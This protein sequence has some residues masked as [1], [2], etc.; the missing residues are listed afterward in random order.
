MILYIYIA[1]SSMIVIND[2]Y[3]NQ[4]DRL[5]IDYVRD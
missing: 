3:T 5:F 1:V 4:T 2:T